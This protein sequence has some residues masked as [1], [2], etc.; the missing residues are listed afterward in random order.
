MDSIKI[1]GLTFYAHHGVFEEEKKNGQTFS[2]DCSFTLDTSICGDDL[3]K[4]VNYGAV[5]MDI[6]QFA[7]ENQFDLLE[8]LANRLAKH[9]LLKYPLMSTITITVHKPHAPIP[10]PFSDVNLTVTR[11]YATCFLAL[12]SNLGDS[13]ANLDSV[14]SLIEEDDQISLE[15]KSSYI[16]TAPYGV[17]DQPDFLNGV[18]KV[19]T[20]YT[21]QELLKFCEKAEKNAQRVKTRV[22]GERTLDVDILTYNDLVLFTEELKIPHAEMHLR[23]F[24]L[25]PFCEIEPYFIHPVLKTNVNSLLEGL[26]S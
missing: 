14:L 25:T 1:E 9:I 13:K 4:T 15:K 18:I 11:G 20:I 17:L 21:P 24:V 26:N 22:W 16:T 10:T 7:T 5:S 2:I 12:G 19:R 23:D 8:M 6:V 3:E